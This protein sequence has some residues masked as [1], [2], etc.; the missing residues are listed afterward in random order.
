MP[1]VSACGYG[2]FK[3][4]RVTQR[5][6]ATIF[7]AVIVFPFIVPVTITVLPA[8]SA[9]AGSFWFSSLYTLPFEERMYSAP[10]LMQA[11]VQSRSVRFALCSCADLWFTPHLLSPIIPVQV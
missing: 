1:L 4:S 11:S 10:P 7:D 8:F 5:Y 6:F 3:V 2:T 9:R